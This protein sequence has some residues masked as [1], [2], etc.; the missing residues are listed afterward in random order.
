MESTFAAI[1]LLPILRAKPRLGKTTLEDAG[2]RP[3]SVRKRLLRFLSSAKVEPT[4]DLPAIDYDEVSGW[5]KSRPKPDGSPQYMT[6]KQAHA[7]FAVVPDQ[8]LATELCAMVE[9][10]LDGANAVFPR[11]PPDPLTGQVI[12][13]PPPGDLLDFR[14]AWAVVCDPSVI[15]EDTA[16]GDLFDDQVLTLA[17]H[18]PATYE[19]VKAAVVETVATMVSRRGKTWRPDPLKEAML[20]TLMQRP[21]VDTMLAGVMQQVYGA[22]MAAQAQTAAPPKKRSGGSAGS[23]EGGESTPGQKA[24]AS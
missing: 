4:E 7:L 20:D 17:T 23:D 12:E 18:F 19:D 15:M 13:E 22:E 11:S 2:N 6:P 1:G 21:Q 9:R 10:I 3:K 24:A 14:R 16:S 8:E 5:L